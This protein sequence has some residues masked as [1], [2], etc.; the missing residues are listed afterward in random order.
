MTT[1]PSRP[2]TPRM[3]PETGDTTWRLPKPNGPEDRASTSPS[4]TLSPRRLAIARASCLP[5]RLIAG[6]TSTVCNCDSGVV[7]AIGSPASTAWPS[8]TRGVN[9]LMA[10][11]YTNGL[12][13][14]TFLVQA[15]QDFGVDGVH[16]L[17]P[18]H[19][20]RLPDQVVG[21]E[22]HRPAAR[23]HDQP[24]NPALNGLTIPFLATIDLTAGPISV[25]LLQ[26]EGD[27]ATGG[28]S[29]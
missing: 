1:T 21:G 12:A 27:P 25:A 7:R 15:R 20:M 23:V 13:G 4:V 28:D 29:Q 10:C 19:E 24:Q 2:S 18:F 8:W 14:T 11:R 9:R 5:C 26:P 22:D 17:E 16:H 6:P 3:T